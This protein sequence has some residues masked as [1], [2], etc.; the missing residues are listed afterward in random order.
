MYTYAIDYIIQKKSHF[1]RFDAIWKRIAI[2]P[3]TNPY[4]PYNNIQKEYQITRVCNITCIHGVYMH[5]Q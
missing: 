1:I 4:I 3:E 2:I 5:I